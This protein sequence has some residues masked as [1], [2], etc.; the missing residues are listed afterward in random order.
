LARVG[1]G[2]LILSV[3]I[4]FMVADL[5]LI[6]IGA[7][8]D[9][10][11]DFTCCY[12]QAA[13]RV[14]DDPSTLYR[15]SDTYTFRYT[16]LGALPFIPLVPLGEAAAA[17]TWLAVK[18]GVLAVAAAW[19]SRPWSGNRRWLVA[20]LVVTFPPIVHDLVIG[21]VSTITLLVLLAVARWQ[22]ARGGVALGLLS[23]LMPKPHL[24]PVLVY[25][26]IRRPRDFVATLATMMG[27]VLVGLGIFGI[28]PWIAFIGTLREPL[29]R[30]F[31]ANVGFSGL[32][33]QLGVGIGLAAG[34]AIL[35]VGVIAGG[36]RGYGLSIIGGIVMGPY[37]FIHYLAGT[38]VAAEP[39]LRTQPRRLLPF[40][41]LLVIFPLIPFWLVGLAWVVRSSP[42][43]DAAAAPPAVGPG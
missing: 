29:E 10:A 1:G 36:S 27:G 30:T 37:T 18:L 35:V 28:D 9:F 6:W 7:Q 19:F 25:I 40:P 31:T 8:A 3:A 5:T 32:F 20:L 43:A 42:P 12:Q 39:V 26:A 17:W 24:I 38:L 13:A 11:F 34:L 15:W 14:L 33:G 22:D 23:I 21:N 2:P 4:V 41:W 16:P